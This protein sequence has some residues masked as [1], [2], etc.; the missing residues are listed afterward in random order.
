M[1]AA[2]RAVSVVYDGVLV[3]EIVVAVE[4]IRA[5]EAV[6]AQ[7]VLLDADVI[8]ALQAEAAAIPRRGVVRDQLMRPAEEDDSISVRGAGHRVPG[9]SHVVGQGDDQPG[10]LVVTRLAVPDLDLVGALHDEPNGEGRRRAALDFAMRATAK[11]Y[12]VAF[13]GTR[14]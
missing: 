5:D 1:D 9:D 7:R 4:E 6:I 12:A 14:R 11:M 3:D 2:L 10:K 8:G 13:V